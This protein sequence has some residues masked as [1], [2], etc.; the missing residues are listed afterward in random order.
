MRL[1]ADR[2]ATA[3]KIADLEA[4]ITDLHRE[5]TAQKTATANNALLHNR[6]ETMATQLNQQRTDLETAVAAGG[7]IHGAASSSSS[8]NVARVGPG[9]PAYESRTDAV[10]MEPVASAST[11]YS[12]YA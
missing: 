3:S 4:M 6:V 1:E 2:E 11:W 9:E 10:M 12:S 8:W 5:L 7:A